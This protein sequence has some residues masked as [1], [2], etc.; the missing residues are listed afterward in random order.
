MIWWTVFSP[1]YYYY[2]LYG[3]LGIKRGK[4]GI[5]FKI[6]CVLLPSEI[7]PAL[8]WSPCALW[9][10]STWWPTLPIWA[11]SPPPRWRSL[12]QWLLWVSPRTWIVFMMRSSWYNRNGWL[13][14]NH[15]ITYLLLWC[16]IQLELGWVLIDNRDLLL[17]KFSWGLF[18]LISTSSIAD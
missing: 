4:S 16:G 7:C 10:V 6:I 17:R 1:W 9:S 12:L 11:F 15:Q 14:M 2:Y 5:I 18:Y 8:S 13:G 3:W